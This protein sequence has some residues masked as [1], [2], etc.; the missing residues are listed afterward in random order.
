[1]KEWRYISRNQHL[2]RSDIYELVQKQLH[3]V[4]VYFLHWLIEMVSHYE[5]DNLMSP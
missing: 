5:I 1:M 4:P 2:Q 3:F